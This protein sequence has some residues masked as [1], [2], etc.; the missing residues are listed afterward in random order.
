MSNKIINRV[1]YLIMIVSVEVTVL[2]I[3][4]LDRCFEKAKHLKL[5]IIFKLSYLTHWWDPNKY[6]HS[7]S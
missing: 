2:K 5:K 7:R 6:Y 4:K 3:L 1:S